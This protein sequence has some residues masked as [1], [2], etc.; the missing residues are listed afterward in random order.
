MVEVKLN[1]EIECSAADCW[2]IFGG[3]YAEISVWKSGMS[4]ST[5]EGEPVGDS[6][7]GSRK[8]KAS[9]LTFSEKLV[10]FNNAERAFTYEVVGLPFVVSSAK[11][12]WKFTETNGTATLQMHLRLQTATGF[13]WILNGLLR[14]NLTK[15]M[16]KLHQEFKYFMENGEVHPRKAKEM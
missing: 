6:P 13:G 1:T 11:N 14:K 3:K 2:Q 7:I 10:H 15:E 4:S 5:A 8:L 12:E 16:G 9:G